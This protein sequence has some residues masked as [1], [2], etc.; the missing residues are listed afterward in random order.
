MI[1]TD[2]ERRSDVRHDFPNIIE[3]ALSTE[4]EETPHRGVTTNISNSGLCFYAFAL[5]SQDQ[6]ITIKQFMLPV[7]RKK[8]VVRWIRNIGPSVYMVGSKFT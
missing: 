7:S 5:L 2:N 6:T 1:I 8:A 4:S 3:Y